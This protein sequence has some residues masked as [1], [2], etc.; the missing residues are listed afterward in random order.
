MILIILSDSVTATSLAP[1]YP[2]SKDLAPK[3]SLASSQQSACTV[4]FKPWAIPAEFEILDLDCQGFKTDLNS[5][6]LENEG[7]ESLVKVP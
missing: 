7:C 4:L 6:A 5:L 1:D 3:I 2:D